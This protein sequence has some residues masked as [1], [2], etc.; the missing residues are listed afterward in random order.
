MTIA[1][2]R[3]LFLL[4]VTF[5]YGAYDWCSHPTAYIL[6]VRTREGVAEIETILSIILAYLI[7]SRLLYGMDSFTKHKT[8]ASVL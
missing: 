3:L 8:S 2:L 5:H 7:P 4:F 6:T 1:S